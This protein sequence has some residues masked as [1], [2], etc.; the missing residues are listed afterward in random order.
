MLEWLG[1]Q[2]RPAAPISC[3]NPMGY[4]AAVASGRR[5]GQDS[6]AGE[7]TSGAGVWSEVVKRHFAA[8]SDDII[9]I[10]DG[11]VKD[12]Q[13]PSSY[14]YPGAR[15]AA[16]MYGAGVSSTSLSP[17]VDTLKSTLKRSK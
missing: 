17:L 8:C 11:W 2:N 15:Y 14:N 9:K 13:D 10:V 3:Y 7:G 16:Q 5:L 6:N 1:V 4:Q 12:T